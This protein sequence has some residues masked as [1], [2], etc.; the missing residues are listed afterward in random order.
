[1]EGALGAAGKVSWADSGNDGHAK[2]EV[3]LLACDGGG[4]GEK[5]GSEAQRQAENEEPETCELFA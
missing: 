3:V 2:I 4:G 5:V 1:M